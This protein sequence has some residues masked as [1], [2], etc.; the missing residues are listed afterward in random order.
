MMR[1]NTFML[2]AAILSIT[3]GPAATSS[4][5]AEASCEIS[6]GPV[7]LAETRAMN[8][9]ARR[10]RSVADTRTVLDKRRASRVAATPV[11]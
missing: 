10:G 6:R 7:E 9:A 5:H 11:R 1:S 2:S 4:A 8:E 3:L